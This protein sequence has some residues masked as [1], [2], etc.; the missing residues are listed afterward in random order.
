MKM[1]DRNIVKTQEELENTL[2]SYFTNLMK[3]LEG[4]KEESQREVFIHI[5]ELI[6]DDH[7]HMPGK[8]IEMTEVEGDIKKMAKDKVPGP[9][10]AQMGSLQTFSM[11]VG[12]G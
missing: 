12:T 7:N 4:D 2:N 8:P 1:E 10:G 11:L 5:P 6:I 3:E 9:D